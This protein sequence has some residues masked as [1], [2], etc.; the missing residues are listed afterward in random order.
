[1]D[2]WIHVW[3]AGQV[4]EW[5]DG[6]VDRWMDRW[7]DGL[8]DEWIDGWMDGWMDGQVDG[9]IDGCMHACMDQGSTLRAV[10]GLWRVKI[11]L[12][13]E[14]KVSLAGWQPE[15]IAEVFHQH[16]GE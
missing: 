16:F 8:M 7:M 5:M 2:G 10:A 11:T 15:I 12:A 9:R 14:F 4:D 1:M 13:S 6:Q 3:T